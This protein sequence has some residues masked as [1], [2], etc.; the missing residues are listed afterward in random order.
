[1]PDSRSAFSP[2]RDIVT[3]VV[4]PG[5]DVEKTLVADCMTSGP[6]TISQDSPIEA[7]VAMMRAGRFRRLPVV[8]EREQLV[9][10]V[11]LDDILSLLAEEFTKIGDLVDSVSSPQKRP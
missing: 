7:A 1:M 11:S 3:R 6:V 9:G 2:D 4:A 5:L 8:G 10:L